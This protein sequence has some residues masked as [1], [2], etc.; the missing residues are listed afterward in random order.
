MTFKT[1]EEL[2]GKTDPK[3][4]RGGRSFTNAGSAS[5]DIGRKEL[6]ALFRK[7]KPYSREAVSVAVKL[8]NA[9]D[10]AA[11][12]QLQAAMA[13]LKMYESLVTKIYDS[14]VPLDPD[15]DEEQ[16]SAP[17][18]RLTVAGGRDTNK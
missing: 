18:V 3:I 6:L 5:K 13:L 15:G 1:K 16:D 4:Y 9:P 14:D 8:M 10:V 2:D 11:A 12:T 17:I 7:V